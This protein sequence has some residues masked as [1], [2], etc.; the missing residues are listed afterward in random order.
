MDDDFRVILLQKETTRGFET[1][2]NGE[3]DRGKLHSEHFKPR[4]IP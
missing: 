2:R 1:E 3:Q 4:F